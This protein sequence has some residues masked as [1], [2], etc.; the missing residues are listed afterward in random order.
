[1]PVL[2]QLGYA[3]GLF[4]LIPLGDVTQRKRLIVVQ[5]LVL[6]AAL[7]ASATVTTLPLLLL[8]SLL[9][10]LTATVSQQI[11]PLAAHL[12]APE[13]R[14]QVVGLVMSGLLS[15]ILL[16]RTIA[17]FVGSHAGWREMFW[18]GVPVALGGAALMALSLPRS[19]PDGR[20]PYLQLLLSMASLWRELPQLR[21]AALMQG[22]LF[23]TFSGFWTVLVFRLQDRFG[24]GADMAGL[25]GIMGL[26]GILARRCPDGWRKQEGLT[27]LSQA[28]QR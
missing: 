24:L 19:Q 16:S 17:G 6:A 27:W 10:G 12:A 11:V 8:A 3:A 25:F 22:L 20:R 4:L 21:R 26:A 14:G 13:R 15:G 23:A 7:A 1:V 2:T 18:L 28:G 9:L 5:F